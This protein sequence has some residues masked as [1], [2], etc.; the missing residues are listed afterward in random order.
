MRLKGKHHARPSDLSGPSHH[1]LKD[2]LMTEV[3]PV[4]VPE[5]EDGLGIGSCI[6][7]RQILDN[8]HI[9]S[10][11]V[12]VWGAVRAVGR[13]GTITMPDAGRNRKARSGALLLKNALDIGRYSKY[14][15]PFARRYTRVWWLA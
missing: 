12:S 2:R 5:R 4:K 1:V 8:L 6:K 7:G 15:T 3:H 13:W 10:R 11:C 9:S 14:K